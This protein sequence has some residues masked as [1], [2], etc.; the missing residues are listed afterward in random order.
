AIRHDQRWWPEPELFD[1]TRFLP[2][3]VKR[4]HRSAY[5]PFGGG[6]RVCIGQS[7]ALMEATLITAIM[8]QR[9]V[10]DL[11][12]GHPVQP[13]ATFTLRPRYGLRMIARRREISTAEAA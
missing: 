8:S 9:F 10:Y 13:E 5:L 3:N 7:F 1:P 4:H 11:V 6:R 12:P 2:E